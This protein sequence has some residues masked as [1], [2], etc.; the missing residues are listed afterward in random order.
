MQ[1]HDQVPPAGPRR[2]TWILSAS[3][4]VA[5][6]ALFIAG[7]GLYGCAAIVLSKKNP[8]TLT[9][10]TREGERIS[11]ERG[12]GIVLA[13]KAHHQ[14]TDSYPTT[15]AELVPTY[16]TSVAPPTVGDKTWQYKR[17]NRDEFSL[18]FWVGPSYQNDTITHDAKWHADR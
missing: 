11:R 3:V 2:I 14:A 12:D 16:L 15:L 6:L 10:P 7:N 8:F 5:L 9:P 17:I 18:R 13:L 1:S 4:V